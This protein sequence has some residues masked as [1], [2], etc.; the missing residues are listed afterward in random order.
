MFKKEEFKRDALEFIDWITEYLAGVENFP[1]RSQVG[2]GDI[3]NKF[4][5]G[6]PVH[7]ESISSI[8]NDFKDKIIPGITHWQSPKYFAYFPA[9]S[10]PPSVLA[11]MLTATL[12]V[13]GM[14]WIT[15]PSATELEELVC[16]WMR[17]MIG[18]PSE[19]SGVIQDTASV[20]T[21]CAI[22]A[23]REKATHFQSNQKGLKGEVLRVYCSSEAHSSI[24]KAVRIAG[25]GS[26]NLV[27]I[28]ADS[29][30][31]LVTKDLEACILA[32]I[33]M[34]FTPICIVAA[35]G[36]TGV[37]AIDP[38]DEIGRIAVKHKI[39]L[40]IDAAFAG[41]ALV[42]PE[43]NETVGGLQRADSFVF[44]PHKWMF[45]NFDCSLFFIRDKIH[46]QNTF[47]LVPGYLQTGND[48]E[49]NDYS[50]WGIHLGRRFRALKLW[51]VIRNF[52][53][54]GIQKRLREHIELAAYFENRIRKNPKFEIIVPR[55]LSV[56]C[57]RLKGSGQESIA[58]QNRINSEMLE[59]I[60]STGQ[61][62]I[63][64]T[65]FHGN[66]TLRF[67]CAQTYTEK[68]HV[69][70]ALDVIFRMADEENI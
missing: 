18:L 40:H 45:T 65:L 24:E 25:L 30:G 39:W 12:A 54:E 11:E 60:N 33:K 64:H 6:P 61:I 69:D 58:D 4:P 55:T 37:C 14:K 51:F 67:V 34:G 42:L 32:D 70:E 66:Y 23:A 1:V 53:L 5:S 17:Q 48:S 38:V 22:L 29:K 9:N 13:Q 36:T 31:R 19:F 8:F 20:A 43:F 44:N 21:L 50:N 26:E 56:V 68:R 15:S 49:V 35:L 47:R 52:G 62:Y 7:G 2:Y 16:D 27:K 57:F 3:R 59:K 41:S 10:S 28:E 46:L 63:S